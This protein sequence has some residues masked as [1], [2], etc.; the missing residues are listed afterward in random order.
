MLVVEVR[1]ERTEIGKI[2][3]ADIDIEEGNRNYLLEKMRE[4]VIEAEEA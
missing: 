2:N 4:A 1:L 3:S